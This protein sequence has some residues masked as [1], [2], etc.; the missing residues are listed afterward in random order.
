MDARDWYDPALVKSRFLVLS[1]FVLALDQWSKLWIETTLELHG[2]LPVLPGFFDLVHVQNTGIAFG[3]FPAGREVASTLLLTALGFAALSV[4]SLY[5]RST[6]EREPLLLLSL[7]LVLGGA[8]GNLIDR[9]LLRA[10]TDFLDVY[11]G[12]HH[13]PAFNVADS[14]VT[15]GIVLMLAHSFLPQVRRRPGGAGASRRG[16]IQARTSK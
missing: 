4:V 5:F 8:V 3:L 15:I 13:W 14:G 2:R 7:A 9:I 6:S 10:V 12:T 16:L 1:A 11:V